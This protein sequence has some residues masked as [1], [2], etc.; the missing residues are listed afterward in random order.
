MSVAGGVI[1]SLYTDGGLPIISATISPFVTSENMI[2]FVPEGPDHGFFTF[3]TGGKSLL[4]KLEVLM[5]RT[6]AKDILY[7]ENFNTV[8]ALSFSDLTKAHSLALEMVT[9]Y[10]M[11]ME[12][13]CTV[14]NICATHCDYETCSSATRKL[15]N[16]EAIKLVVNAYNNAYTLLTTHKEKLHVL[17]R[18]LLEHK[19]LT[20][21]EI[22]FHLFHRVN[23]QKPSVPFLAG[24]A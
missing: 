3:T 16:T 1:T 23:L 19:T 13:G 17:C 6:V 20:G 15:I 8:G 21:A 11:T 9:E 12:R 7:E 14:F 10:G 5:A 24:T 22:N 4:A 18:A 2:T